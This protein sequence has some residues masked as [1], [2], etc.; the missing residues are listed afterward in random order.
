[1]RSNP[2][3]TV[4]IYQIEGFLN[5]AF[6]SAV[7]PRNI[8]SGLSS[9][10]IFSY[11]REIVSER[12]DPELQPANDVAHVPHKSDVVKKLPKL[13]RPGGTTQRKQLLIF[14]CNLQ[15]QKLE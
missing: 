7:T 13:K 3:K 9:T 14:P 10:G 5:E 11:N 15:G 1:M 12:P 4:S 2:G 8:T 6:M